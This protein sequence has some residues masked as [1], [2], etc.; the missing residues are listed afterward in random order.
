MYSPSW[1]LGG[2]MAGKANI[3][4]LS[5]PRLLLC[6]MFKGVVGYVGG[7]PAI[8]SRS[9]RNLKRERAIKHT[10]YIAPLQL[11]HGLSNDAA[12]LPGGAATV[13]LSEL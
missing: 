11:Q 13:H 3:F 9:S 10:K 6:N 7:F 1:N 5:S 4:C 2:G 8:T 12:H